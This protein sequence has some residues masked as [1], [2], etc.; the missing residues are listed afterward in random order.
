MKLEQ[1]L[2]YWV[3][4]NRFEDPEEENAFS[5]GDRFYKVK[6][7]TIEILVFKNEGK[8]IQ[9]GINRNPISTLDNDEFVIFQL[10]P[11]TYDYRSKTIRMLENVNMDFSDG[12]LIVIER[13]EDYLCVERWVRLSDDEAELIQFL[14]H[15]V[16]NK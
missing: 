7:V 16:N 15:Q 4:E 2:G 10:M 11:G 6:E 1:L 9:L 12:K 14:N 3:L 8:C 13:T 5:I